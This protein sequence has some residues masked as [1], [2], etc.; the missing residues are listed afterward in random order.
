MR[1]YHTIH[2]QFYD[3]TFTV[4]PQL[5]FLRTR[6]SSGMIAT[7]IYRG[8]RGD[9]AHKRRAI[10]RRM[11]SPAM[12]WVTCGML[13][14][15]LWFS[16][17]RESRVR[18]PARKP[19]LRNYRSISGLLLG[20]YVRTVFIRARERAISLESDAWNCN[21]DKSRAA[22]IPNAT[23]VTKVVFNSPSRL[24]HHLWLLRRWS[25]LC[26]SNRFFFKS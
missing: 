1:R 16:V 4:F 3:E 2:L 11:R 17:E 26:T 24:L 25:P 22:E 19:R 7:Q 20:R 10:P 14:H 5:F 21:D 18:A 6:I 8:N 9:G 23:E 15:F 12:A 13:L